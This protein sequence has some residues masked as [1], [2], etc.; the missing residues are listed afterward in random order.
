[1]ML[2]Q[3]MVRRAFA[4]A[5]EK[6]IRDGERYERYLMETSARELGEKIKKYHC[7]ILRIENVLKEN[8]DFE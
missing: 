8:N 4:E 3:D 7:E 2:T 5:A 6:L 1:M